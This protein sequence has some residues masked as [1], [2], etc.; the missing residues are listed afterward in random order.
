MRALDAKVETVNGTGHAK[1]RLPIPSPSRQHAADRDDLKPGEIITAVTLP[2]P[3]PGLQIYRKVRDRASYAFALVSVAAIV[4]APP[5]GKSVRRALPLADWPTSRG[6]VPRR[7]KPGGAP[8]TSRPSMRPPPKSWTKPVASAATI[9][10]SRS[11]AEPCVRCCRKPP[12]PEEA[13]H[14]NEFTV[15]TNALDADAQGI[16]G[17]PLSRV[18]GHLKVTGGARYAFEMEQ[19][20]GVAYGFVVEASIGKGKIRSIDT[21]RRRARRGAS[22]AD[23]SQCAATRRRQ[24]SRSS[25]R[26]HGARGDAIRPAGC[27]RGGRKL[28]TSHGP[29]RILSA[30]TMTVLREN[31]RCAMV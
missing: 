27:L 6:A 8:A 24:S 5:V 25:S 19:G 15:G 31:T 2:P 17:K 21:G 10:R 20:P 1:F 16:V 13:S 12:G 30:P 9:S 3:P 26:A 18:D 11:P 28:R 14:G 29:R 4:D 22:G 7:R 23:P